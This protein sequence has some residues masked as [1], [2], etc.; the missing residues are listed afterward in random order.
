M[1]HRAATTV[2]EYLASIEEDRRGELQRVLDVV[3]ANLP[4]GYEER[5]LWGMIGWSIPLARYPD[6]YNKQPLCIAA[7]AAQKHHLALYLMTVYGDRELERRLRAGFE[8]AGKALDMGKSCIRFR[9]ADALALDVIAETIRAVGVDAYIASY[10]RS[11]RGSSKPPKAKAAAYAARSR[12]K[13]ASRSPKANKPD[14]SITP[15]AKP[16]KRRHVQRR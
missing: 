5:M 16:E 1:V 3:R 7:L 6:T 2:D 14:K 15:K 9:S 4:A 8:A 13:Q 11:R 10:E 12:L